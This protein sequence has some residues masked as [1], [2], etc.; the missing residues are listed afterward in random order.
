MKIILGLDPGSR[1]T[2]YAVLEARGTEVRYVESGILKSK[3]DNFLS[4]LS[5][6]SEDLRTLL[7]E[8]KPDCTVVEKIFLGKNPQS[9]FTLGQLRGV[10]LSEALRVK[11]RVFEYAARTVKKGIT[12]YGDSQKEEVQRVLLARLDLRGQLVLDASDALALAYYYSQ[13]AELEQKL[14]RMKDQEQG[15]KR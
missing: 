15:L 6:L 7:D 1:Q 8:F 2:G 3:S 11:S 5:D 4:R 14:Q 9:V 12:G 13:I 10:C